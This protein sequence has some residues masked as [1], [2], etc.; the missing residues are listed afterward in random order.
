MQDVL[1]IAH[2]GEPGRADGD[3]SGPVT[4]DGTQPQGARDRHR[5]HRGAEVDEAVGQPGR[6]VF[7][8]GLR[9]FA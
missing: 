1:H 5:Q 6:C 9:A 4:Q 2:Q 8:G 3:A 7:D